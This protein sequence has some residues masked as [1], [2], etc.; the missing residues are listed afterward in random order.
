MKKFFLVIL[1]VAYFATILRFYI[2]NN[3]IISILGSFI[4]GFVFAKKISN[5][6]KEIYLSGFCACFTS[7]SGFINYLYY[8]FDN[9][10]FLKLFIYSNLIIIFNILIM[11]FGFLISRKTN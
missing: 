4:Y 11:Y 5:S 7:F 9:G 1:L 10:Y 2:D 3:F 8:F 6:K